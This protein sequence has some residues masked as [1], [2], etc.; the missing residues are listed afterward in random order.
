MSQLRIADSYVDAGTGVRHTWLKQQWQGI[1]I[2]NSE[3]A[4]H[5]RANGD[6]VW[7]PIEGQG[8]VREGGPGATGDRGCRSAADGAGSGWTPCGVARQHRL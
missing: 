8:L 5:Q 3:I 4:L 1:D 7:R 2:F 6:V